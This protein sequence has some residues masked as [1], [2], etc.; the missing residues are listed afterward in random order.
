MRQS[1]K[2]S[3]QGKED[4]KFD[5]DT[6][7]RTIRERIRDII[8]QVVEAELDAALGAKASQRVGEGRQGYRHGCRERTLT[9]STGP[10]TLRCRG[11]G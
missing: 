11:L 2:A 9:T 4:I 1:I 10:T 7:E 3:S 8:E 6:I 5:M